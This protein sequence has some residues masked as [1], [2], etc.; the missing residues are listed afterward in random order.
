MVY[1]REPHARQLAFR[2]VAQP[3][4]FEERAAL[5]RRMLEELELDVE[6]WIDDLGDR[7]R[8]TFGDLPSWAVV[9]SSGGSIR[10]KLA[11]PDPDSLQKLVANLPKP[12]QPRTLTPERRR[13]NRIRYSLE[14]ADK[15]RTAPLYEVAAGRE[16]RMHNRRAHLA[17]LVEAA[18]DHAARDAWLL[19]LCGDG[20][21]YQ[22]A[23]ALAQR[24]KDAQQNDSR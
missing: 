5:A 11:W 24:S 8:A 20:P 3:E 6:V 10:R 16:L 18:P 2:D 15:L 21:T 9:I 14:Q 1:Q 23:W 17:Y 7:S 22:R 4:T 12:N 19:E 13:A